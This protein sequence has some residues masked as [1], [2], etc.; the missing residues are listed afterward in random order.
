MFKIFSHKVFENKP[1][2]LMH[3]G[4]AGPNFKEW[5]NITKFS[6][7]ISI[8]GAD[9]NKGQSK[10]YKRNI[11]INNVISNKKHKTNFYITKDSHCSSLLKPDSKE[12]KK[13][14]FEHRFKVAKVVKVKTITINQLLKDLKINYIDW[15][16]LD[17]Q[18]MDLKVLKS[19]SSKLRKKII[20]IDVEPG[21]SN[22]Y[23]NE[24][25]L[26]EIF[27]F[28]H[29]EYEIEDITFGHNYKISNQKLNKFDKKTLFFTEKKRKIY[30]NI[31]FLKKIINSSLREQLLYITF[32]LIKKRFFE[33][34]QLESLNRSNEDIHFEIKKFLKFKLFIFKLKYILCLPYI[35]LIKIIK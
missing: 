16:V 34:S 9:D 17:I 7:I 32:L 5:K 22:F 30:A 27:E 24:P 28:M 33:V 15:L 14:Y 26:H 23:K 11:K 6:T 10:D 3:I 20:F 8:D 4:S 2:V 31:S 1:P 12:L 29:K 21:L 25:K 35:F 19:L 18:G 13:W